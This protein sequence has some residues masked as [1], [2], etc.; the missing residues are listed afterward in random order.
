MEE[1]IFPRPAVAGILEETYVEARL[2]ADGE[3]NV[4]RIHALQDAMAKSRATPLYLV[5]DP[6]TQQELARQEGATSEA[7]FREFLEQGVEASRVRVS[8]SR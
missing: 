5:V 7:K 4:E 8:S 6:S 2:H 3:V 1:K